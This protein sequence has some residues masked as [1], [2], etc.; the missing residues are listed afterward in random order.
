MSAAEATP[1]QGIIFLGE[2]QRVFSKEEAAAACGCRPRTL[3][4]WIKDG[5][6]PR[7]VKVEV[8]Q[9]IVCVRRIMVSRVKEAD[10][11]EFLAAR[12]AKHTR[13]ADR[14]AA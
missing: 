1:A 5:K 8:E 7:P 4:R 12:N 9:E 6:F 11:A 14:Q 2:M 3:E 13:P 10:L